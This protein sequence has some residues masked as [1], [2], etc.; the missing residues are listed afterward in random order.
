M[1]FRN[2]ITIPLSANKGINPHE[3]ERALRHEYVHAVIAE[4]SGHRCPAWLDEGIAQF[5]EGHANPLLGPA[6]RDWISENHAMP[7]GWLKDGFT[8][9]NSE[10]V[11]AAYAQSLFAARSL[12]NTLGFSAVTKYL[13]LLKAG[14]PENRAFKRAFQKSKSDFED[15]LTAQIERWARSSREDP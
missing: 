3:L 13:K 8:S 5:I 10:L 7:L 15:S 4:L 12:V 11:P 2:E 9:L 14:V 1:Y 6:L